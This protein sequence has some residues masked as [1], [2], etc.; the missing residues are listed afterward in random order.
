MYIFSI[1]YQRQNYIENIF[2]PNCLYVLYRSFIVFAKSMSRALAAKRKE[3]VKWVQ[4]AVINKAWVGMD[5]GWYFK[6]KQ[7]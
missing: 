6:K 1:L 2:E 3:L 4:G 5:I 7:K